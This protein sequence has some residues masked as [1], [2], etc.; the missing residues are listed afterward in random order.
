MVSWLWLILAFFGGAWCGLFTIA[1]CIAA[2]RGDDN[3]R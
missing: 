2:K 1:L 3:M